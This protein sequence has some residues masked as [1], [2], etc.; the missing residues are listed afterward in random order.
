MSVLIV[1]DEIVVGLVIRR[2][3][4]RASGSAVDP[5][6]SAAREARMC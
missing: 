3:I 6:R 2:D 1:E 5:V 4:A